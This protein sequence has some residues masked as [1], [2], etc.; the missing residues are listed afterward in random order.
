MTGSPGVSRQSGALIFSPLFI[1]FAMS[2]TCGSLRASFF[3]AKTSESRFLAFGATRAKDGPDCFDVD[4]GAAGGETRT[5]RISG[6]R[7][8]FCFCFARAPAWDSS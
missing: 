1:G 2:R 7:S 3:F 4:N 8:S 6:L 5:C